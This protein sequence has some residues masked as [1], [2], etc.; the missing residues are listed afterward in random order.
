MHRK[1]YLLLLLFIPFMIKAQSEITMT[2]N[3][4]IKMASQQSLDAFLAK[5][6][7]HADYW[8]YRSYKA[9]RLPSLHLVATPVDY[10]RGIYQYWDNDINSW[11]TTETE[12]L[13]INGTFKLKQ[14][15]GLTGGTLSLNTG[16]KFL[17]N[18][19]SANTYTSTP[20]SATYTQNLNGYNS[21][22]WEAKIDPEK[23]KVAKQEYLEARE[24]IAI[25][26][27]DYFFSLINAQIELD[28]NTR[29]LT[30]AEELF[31]IGKGRFEV[32]TITQDELLNLE[33]SYYNAKL[34]KTKAEQSLLRARI[35]L[36]I[37]LNI[38]K[39]TIINCIIPENIPE[40]EID[41]ERALTE[42][43]QNNSTLTSL[44]I[45]KLEKEKNLAK[46]KADN[47]FSSDLDISYGLNGKNSTFVESYNKLDKKQSVNISLQIPI[48]DWGEGRGAVA[49]AKSNLR[50][51]EIQI[52]QEIISFEQNV[53]VNVLEFNLQKVQVQISAKADTIAKKGYDISYEI[54]K[55][56][57]LDVI[58][59]NQ[60][61]ND[62]E[63]A[64][65][66]YIT[67]LKN[68]W[69]YWYN[70]RKLTLY[71]FEKQLTLSEDFDALINK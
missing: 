4:C 35:N 15:I 7:Y 29:N 45:R 36:N 69:T 28:I 6:M 54:F 3:D 23:Y 58:N 60:A 1:K 46:T 33:L 39:T 13:N 42:A 2:L 14:K 34:D 66:A 48:L 26:A 27:I 59:L 10:Y 12:Y 30:N 47:R 52:E 5:N 67:S 43:M 20:L 41:A 16:N 63:S 21:L 68:Y 11:A 65:K 19:S 62:Q 38:D 37:F 64:K 18:F 57:K 31:K 51:E 53:N 61:R 56:G 71:D 44:R 9:S 32:G 40:I 17:N 49:V 24:T 22:R 70:I 25:S 50:A 8:D 55:L